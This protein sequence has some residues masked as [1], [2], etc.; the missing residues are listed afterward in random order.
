[1][2]S[3]YQCNGCFWR[4]LGDGPDDAR[5]IY[6]WQKNPIS[7]P[8]P[9]RRFATTKSPPSPLPFARVG[10]SLHCHLQEDL[11]SA[12]GWRSKGSARCDG[13]LR[14]RP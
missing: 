11:P 8:P 6:T 13:K 12:G 14:D 4:Q 2:P 1:M 7:P 10:W 5:W 3:W 9:F